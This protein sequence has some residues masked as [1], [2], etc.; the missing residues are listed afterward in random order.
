[1]HLPTAMLGLSVLATLTSALPPQGVATEE[2]TDSWVP[3]NISGVTGLAAPGIVPSDPAIAS[4]LNF[5]QC[6]PKNPDEWAIICLK[7]GH[8][9]NKCK[10]SDYCI[11]R[12]REEGC[13]W[14]WM[15]I[16]LWRDAVG[17]HWCYCKLVKP[18]GENEPLP[19]ID[20]PAKEHGVIENPASD[21]DTAT[22]DVQVRHVDVGDTSV[23][24]Y[25]SL[26]QVPND[27]KECDWDNKNQWLIL[28]LKDGHGVRFCRLTPYVV[29]LRWDRD[30]S[31]CDFHWALDEKNGNKPGD[32]WCYCRP[33]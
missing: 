20:P 11:W 21:Y 8:G 19:E 26:D 4:D 33:H 18:Q 3:F 27:G 9:C 32:P 2:I 22:T 15:E 25:A 12:T 14:H 17:D 29:W 6:N 16:D 10:T 28:C 31:I 1:M 24:V 5:L 7:N 30:T 13:P 23:P